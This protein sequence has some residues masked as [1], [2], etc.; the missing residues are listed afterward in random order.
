MPVDMVRQMAPRL[1]NDTA[2]WNAYDYIEQCFPFDVEGDVLD[3]DGGRDD[4]VVTVEGC[5]RG[6]NRLLH[7]LGRG[8]AA[9]GDVGAVYWWRQ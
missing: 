4:L 2:P 5:C 7:G 6:L 1:P 3:D 9:A 8:R